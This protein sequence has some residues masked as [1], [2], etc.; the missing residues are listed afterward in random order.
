MEISKVLENFQEKISNIVASGISSNLG[1]TIKVPG[2]GLLMSTGQVSIVDNLLTVKP[3]TQDAA[4]YIKEALLNTNLFASVINKGNI[5]VAQVAPPT[6][7]RRDSLIKH[8][9]RLLEESKVALK[10]VREGLRQSI[11][12]SSKDELEREK[13]LIDKEVK[14]AQKR[15]E[16]LLEDKISSLKR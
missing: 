12:A 13:K 6:Q 10:K 8:V 2:H 15:L 4:K 16:S 5:I 14:I 11:S 3:Y 1:K 7:E 9:K